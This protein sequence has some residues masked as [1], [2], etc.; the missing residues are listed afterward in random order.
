MGTS[1]ARLEASLQYDEVGRIVGAGSV[2]DASVACRGT[3]KRRGEVWRYSIKFETLT[4]EVRVRVSGLVGSETAAVRY[5]G[6]K[7]KVRLR[8]H[9]VSVLASLGAQAGTADLSLQ[10]DVEGKV[11]GSGRFTSG[12]GNDPQ[13]TG[14]VEGRLRCDSLRLRFESGRQRLSFRGTLENGFFVGKLKV[15]A[16]P[17]RETVKNFSI[18][19]EGKLLEARMTNRDCEPTCGDGVCE[20]G[21]NRFGCPDDCPPAC[22][23]RICDPDE[24]EDSC[25]ADCRPPTPPTC[26]GRCDGSLDRILCPCDCNECGDGL[27]CPGEDRFTCSRDCP[28]PRCGDGVCDF[29][30]NCTTC[31][32]DCPFPLCGDGAC[33]CGETSLTC[34]LDCRA[35]CG[36]GIC[37]SGETHQR[38]PFDC[39]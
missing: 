19:L 31:R 35:V 1:S 21:E 13:G 2:D 32:R 25:P 3:L 20:G 37:E 29:G 12:L 23:D 14:I 15:K 34:S 10:V 28:F 24:D 8:A 39:P 6:P 11:L 9:P 30:E 36:N 5:R 4:R 18:A 33:N 7:G 27:C 22:G 38:C 16:P 17:A 26:D